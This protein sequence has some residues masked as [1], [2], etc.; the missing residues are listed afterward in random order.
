LGIHSPLL[1][2]RVLASEKH[3]VIVVLAI[4]IMLRLIPELVAYPHPIGY[5]VINYYIPVVTSFDEHWATISH[6]F[7]LYVIMLHLMQIT[8]GLQ[9]QSIVTGAAVATFGIFG[10]SLFRLSRSLLKL[11]TNQSIFLVIFVIF[12]MAILRTAWDL[13][14]DLF[15]LALMI[16]TFSLLQRKHD[17][18]KLPS[19]ILGI[20]SIIVAADRM[21]GALFCI[22]MAAYAISS[23]QKNAIVTCICALGVFFLLMID[24]YS[25]SNSASNSIATLT[26]EPP[27]FYNPEKLL[28]L[29]II[30]NGLLIVPATIGFLCIKNNLL[31][32]PLLVSLTGSFSWVA[33]PVISMLVAD[34]WIIVSGVFLSIFAGYGILS[35]IH[36]LKPRL[37]AIIACCILGAFASLGIAYA[38][39]PYDDPFIIYGMARSSIEDFSPVTM[40]FNSLDIQDNDN[41]LSTIQWI[42][43]YTEHNAII[44]GE[45]HLRGFMELYLKDERTY[46][47]S[48]NPQAL[49]ESLDKRGEHVFLIRFDA[50]SPTN[51][52][53]IEYP[54]IR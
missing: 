47:F 30:V 19:V 37:S 27:T 32:I 46:R 35:T 48:E 45:K 18:W 44:V 5:D 24:S 21:I 20:A 8:T 15:T 16:F 51:F 14:R 41:L 7:P 28:V 39:M 34:R 38:V 43:Q 29:F 40:Q 4:S 26:E 22:A 23:R 10:V 49:A 31:K 42:N 17:D 12:Q 25:A 54:H 50:S 36:Y 2:Y 6:Q 3:A 11:T 33:F 1:K 52:I 53:V 13:H 9:A